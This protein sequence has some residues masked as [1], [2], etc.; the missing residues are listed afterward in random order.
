MFDF[1]IDRSQMFGGSGICGSEL[2]SNH[3]KWNRSCV[4]SLSKKNEQSEH[5]EPPASIIRYSIAQ[6]KG[7]WNRTIERS[8]QIFQKLN[9]QVYKK[10]VFLPNQFVYSYSLYYLFDYLFLDQLDPI[11]IVLLF[12]FFILGLTTW[13]VFPIQS[14]QK[15]FRMIETR[16][17]F[18][19]RNS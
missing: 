18:W 4:S 11:F 8:D 16:N 5:Y 13:K 19:F 17:C 9:G 15:Q 12:V 6:N 3:S 2:Y 10:N 7:M 1:S 14:K